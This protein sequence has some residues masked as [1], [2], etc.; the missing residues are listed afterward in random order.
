MNPGP[1]VWG[2]G[3]GIAILALRGILS[4][5]EHGEP[6]LPSFSSS[7]R[8]SGAESKDEQE[9]VIVTI[10][11]CSGEMGDERE[12][13]HILELEH[14]LSEA[15]ERSSTG[16]LDGD[17]FGGGTCTIYMYGPSAEELYSVISPIL[18]AFRAP[19]GS[20][21][22]KRCGKFR[23]TRAPHT[24]Q[25]RLAPSGPGPVSNGTAVMSGEINVSTQVDWLVAWK[26]YHYPYFFW[27]Y[28]ALSLGIR[29][30]TLR[31]LKS[32]APIKTWFLSCIA[33]L[34]IVPCRTVHSSSGVCAG[35]DDAR[36]RGL[37]MA[38]GA[39]YSAIPRAVWWSDR[40][41]VASA[42]VARGCG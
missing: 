19:G 1:S 33:S 21:I 13:R 39:S 5:L 30:G 3:G 17:E 40:L 2:L 20:Y 27:S 14:R 18:R 37:F 26:I 4:R 41:H 25:Q 6:I 36:S 12:R 28:T 29:F 15:I 11:L 23:R 35:N 22:T 38:H 34:L 8:L 10:R 9:A 16:E 24:V 31:L 7:K 32:A 42:G